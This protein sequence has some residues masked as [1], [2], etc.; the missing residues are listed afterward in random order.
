MGIYRRLNQHNKNHLTTTSKSRP[1]PLGAKISLIVALLIAIL[2][3]VTPFLLHHQGHLIS[4]PLT[5]LL[6]TDTTHYS[7]RRFT[8]LHDNTYNLETTFCNI[9]RIQAD[10]LTVASFVG[11]YAG[12][13]PIILVDGKHNQH[14]RAHVT[15]ER[16]LAQYGDV[17]VILSASN[18]YTKHKKTVSVQKY[19]NNMMKKQTIRSLGNET[20]YLFG[21]NYGEEWTPLLDLLQVSKYAG[22][23]NTLSFG[24]GGERSGVPFHF[25]GGGFSEVFHGRKRWFLTSHDNAPTYDPDQSMLQWVQT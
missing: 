4:S 8:L 25:H 16:L 5:S 19:V 24:V 12:K 6:P 20:W 2:A 18:S 14:F 10:Q 13:I 1:L 11:D 3:L 9:P 21:D 7:R 15:R 23:E 17:R 22:K